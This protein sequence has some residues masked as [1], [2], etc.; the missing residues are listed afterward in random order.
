MINAM[1]GVD[2]LMGGFGVAMENL[3]NSLREEREIEHLGL[4]QQAAAWKAHC[5]KVKSDYAV[6]FEGL[7]EQIEDLKRIETDQNQRDIDLANKAKAFNKVCEEFN[8]KATKFN[9]RLEYFDTL[10]NR[11][12]M[13][14]KIVKRQSANQASLNLM[15]E[16]LTEKLR[17][18]MGDEFPADLNFK[19]QTSLIEDHWNLFMETGEFPDSK[20]SKMTDELYRQNKLAGLEPPRS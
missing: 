14:E 15:R 10:K 11:T 3:M 17:S 16:Y 20:L 5:R 1:Q 8:A 2:S 9:S 6:L 18:V 12:D 13:L 4:V 19:K 7:R